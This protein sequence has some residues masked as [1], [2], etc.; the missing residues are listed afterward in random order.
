[1]HL[2][3]AANEKRQKRHESASC[4]CLVGTERVFDER[5]P[6]TRKSTNSRHKSTLTVL[7]FVF[8]ICW[9]HSNSSARPVH[10]PHWL[11]SVKWNSV[12]YTIAL[13]SSRH[14]I[15]HEDDSCRCVGLYPVQYSTAVCLQHNPVVWWH[16]EIFHYIYRLISR[17]YAFYLTIIIRSAY[18]TGSNM[19]AIVRDR[20]WW[21]C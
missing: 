15:L 5:T 21:H 17:Q 6:V 10:N 4:V 18:H 3:E 2:S 11:Q 16:P 20:R 9:P 14:N 12:I 7:Y 1:M 8:K 19:C 13:W